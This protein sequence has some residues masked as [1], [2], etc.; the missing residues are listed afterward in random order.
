[1]FRLRPMPSACLTG[2]YT[3]LEYKGRSPHKA[4]FAT[5]AQLNTLTLLRS[6]GAGGSSAA[7]IGAGGSSGAGRERFAGGRRQR[8]RERRNGGLGRRPAAAHA[9]FRSTARR[10]AAYSRS[11]RE[12]CS[13][14][15]GAIAA[16]C[17][18]QPSRATA[19]REL[20]VGLAGMARALRPK[21]RSG[22]G[23]RGMSDEHPCAI[24]AP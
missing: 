21:A 2:E 10:R 4:S 3:E 16:D 1:M 5:L 11:S 18:H 23:S 19:A 22:A 20:R 6:S 12:P 9:A 17:L 24:S 7:G 13:E 8:R 14:L 15:A